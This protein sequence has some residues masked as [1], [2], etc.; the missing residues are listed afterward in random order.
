M[1]ELLE[2]RFLLSSTLSANGT[3]TLAG[4]AAGD[5]IVVTRQGETLVV[6]GIKGNAQFPMAS[7]HGLI[8]KG[9]GG[10]DTLD[11]TAAAGMPA[12][13]LGGDGNDTLIGGDSS[14]VLDGQGGD[15]VMMG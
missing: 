14:D 10:K 6:Q 2:S 11:V 8:L 3:L 4:T 15:D 9:S 5:H 13:L 7:V 1:Y 12:T